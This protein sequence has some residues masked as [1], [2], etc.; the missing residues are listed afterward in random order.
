MY[1]LG[2][3]GQYF[4]TVP[5]KISRGPW[6]KEYFAH[7]DGLEYYYKFTAE[8]GKTKYLL[9]NNMPWQDRENVDRLYKGIRRT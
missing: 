2:P 9:S 3:S 6:F 1:G 7:D 8:D 4:G 5:I